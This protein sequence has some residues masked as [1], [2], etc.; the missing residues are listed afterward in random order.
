MTAKQFCA[1]QTAG[2][3]KPVRIALYQ[4]PAPATVSLPQFVKAGSTLHFII[5]WEISVHVPRDSVLSWEAPTLVLT[6]DLGKRL[7]LFSVAPIAAGM[8][9]VELQIGWEEA[10]DD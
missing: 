1:T 3:G 10:S 4:H 9:A 6:D 5:P 2:E 8:T 7:E